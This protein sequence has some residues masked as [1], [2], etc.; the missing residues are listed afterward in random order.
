M[1]V[2]AAHLT[3]HPLPVSSGV[4]ALQ[5]STTPRRGPPVLPLLQLHLSRS[6]AFSSPPFLP[7]GSGSLVP[8]GGDSSAPTPAPSLLGCLHSSDA[9]RLLA[10]PCYPLLGW[11]CNLPGCNQVLLN[12]PHVPSHSVLCRIQ[13]EPC[14]ALCSSPELSAPAD[15][16]GFGR[17]EGGDINGFTHFLQPPVACP[18]LPAL[19]QQKHCQGGCRAE[20]GREKRARSAQ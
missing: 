19:L 15:E 16:A 11:L 10:Q 2:E 5:G 9:C 14:S 1:A 8:P 12:V 4:S 13:S 17:G 6:V 3:G 7:P 18:V 20:A